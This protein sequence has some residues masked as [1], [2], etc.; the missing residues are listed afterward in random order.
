MDNRVINLV[1][2]SYVDEI[3]R[4]PLLTSEEERRLGLAA[5]SGDEDAVRR[6]VE[7]NLRLV[8]KIAHDFCGR[9]LPIEDLVQEGNL[10]LMTAARKFDPRKGAKFSTYCAIWI[11]QRMY[12][13]TAS[14]NLVRVPYGTTW[15]VLK[16]V[17]G[18]PPMKALE[19][20]IR[21]AALDA[22]SAA[23]LALDEVDHDVVGFA[24]ET[25]H[26]VEE[27]TDRERMD[28]VLELIDRVLDP[29]EAE[30]IRRRYPEDGAKET[31]GSIAASLG[32]TRERVRQIESG[33]L[34]KLRREIDG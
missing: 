27:T 20:R 2:K 10:G 31:L 17:D 7:S 25:G 13:A 5:A 28:G 15:K 29:R 12:R 6:L 33:A 32:V 11:K 4:Y 8:L 18:K 34:R 3:K 22:M 1:D 16:P 24:L 23:F 19:R 21:K 26:E 30:V 14:S 9:G